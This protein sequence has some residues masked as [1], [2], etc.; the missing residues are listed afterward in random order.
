[1]SSPTA[2][3]LQSKQCAIRPASAPNVVLSAPYR[4][5]LGGSENRMF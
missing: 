2:G 1:M 5:T 3:P 4:S